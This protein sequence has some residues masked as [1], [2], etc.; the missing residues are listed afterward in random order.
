MLSNASLR[1]ACEFRCTHICTSFQIIEL[2]WRCAIERECRLSVCTGRNVRRLLHVHAVHALCLAHSH[3]QFLQSNTFIRFDRSIRT[4]Q[5][6][7]PST[8]DAKKFYLIFVYQLTTIINKYV[9]DAF[10]L[11]KTHTHARIV[12][13]LRSTLDG[14][15]KE[16]EREQRNENW[17]IYHVCYYGCPRKCNITEFPTPFHY[18]IFFASFIF[19]FVVFHADRL[20]ALQRD[21]VNIFVAHA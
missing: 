18:I 4:D 21:Y 17:H 13:V 10:K 8:A 19:S 16:R 1:L 20:E 9:F 2:N 11:N 3:S 5:T 7:S 12:Y 15:E 14:R 6:D